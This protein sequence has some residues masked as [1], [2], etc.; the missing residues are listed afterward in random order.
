MAD[1]EIRMTGPI[2]DGRAARAMAE[3]CRDARDSIAEFGEEYALALMGAAFR[4]PTGYYES[5]VKT[6]VVSADTALVDDGG[7][8]YGAWLEGVGSR[9]SPV[10]RFPGYIH[11]RRT[12][13]LVAARGP[14]IAEVAV[15][16]HLPEMG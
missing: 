12:K 9:N 3:A 1:V 6:T 15:R 8:V 16:R 14:A 13:A 11:W 7:V 4:H 10:T 2:F 5:N